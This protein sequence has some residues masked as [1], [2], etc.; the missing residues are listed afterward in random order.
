[1]ARLHRCALLLVGLFLLA[2]AGTATA[3]EVY[4]WIDEEGVVHY[5]QTPP[6]DRP[7]VRL[8]VEAPAADDP[9]QA[10]A[11]T[12]AL[13]ESAAERAY[14]ERLEREERERLRQSREERA[15]WCPQARQELRALR[16]R[17]RVRHEDEGYRLMTD[18]ERQRKARAL[19]EK[20][21]RRC[22]NL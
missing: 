16:E 3:V 8:D 11:E 15:A 7:A 9:A 2:M 1:M 4:R 17:A 22:R 14:Q 18:E 21:E 5:S 19:E 20:I 10:R 13:L 12:R 6:S